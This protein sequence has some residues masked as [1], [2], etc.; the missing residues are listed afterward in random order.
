MTFTLNDKR[1]RN[2]LVSCD[3]GTFI[4][5]RFDYNLELAA[6]QGGWL[7]E[8][9]SVNT[10]E[11]QV[12][13]MHILNKNNP[14][15]FDVGAN[16]GTFTSWMAK[17]FPNPQ[18]YAFEPQRIVY[19]MLCGNMAINNIDCV[20]AYNLAL[21]KTNSMSEIFEPDYNHM[22]N[23]GGFSL[24][25]DTIPRSNKKSNV[26]IVTIDEFVSKYHI[27]WVDFIKVDAEGMDLDVL[28]GASKT[29]SECKPTIL[30]EYDNSVPGGV[31]N[32]KQNLEILV[33][34]LSKYN[35]QFDVLKKDLLARV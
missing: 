4:V 34:E 2:V 9:G 23:Y 13:Y 35:Y 16:I 5:N 28:I 27:K 14:V 33:G 20:Y 7:L 26:E 15:I 19:Q 6:G 11:A 32:S 29:I 18:I 31:D 25:G 17:A 12:A 8:H 10:Y 22:Q 21:G 1:S 24:V 3:H 30:V